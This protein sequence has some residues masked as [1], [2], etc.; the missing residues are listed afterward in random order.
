M[1]SNRAWLA[2]VACL[3][4]Q[5]AP[6][7]AAAKAVDVSIVTAAGNDDLARVR[8]LLP[9]HAA[10]VNQT[11]EDGATALAWAARNGNI[12]MARL[13]IKAG[14]DPNRLNG[15]GVGPLLLAAD[16]GN[17]ELV[18]L[19]LAAGA[20]PNAT[21]WNKETALM[22]AARAGSAASIQALV[23]AGADV[24]AREARGGQTALMWAAASGK[25]AAVRA[26]LGAKANA[27]LA[28]PVVEVGYPNARASDALE[29]QKKG[30]F[31]ALLFAA[32][33]FDKDT[34]KALLD[35]G[36]DPNRAAADGSTPLLIS[37]YHH[38]NP[39]PDFPSDTEVVADL[40]TADLLLSR[41][42]D[43]NKADANGLTPL[44]AAVFVAQ[45]HDLLGSLTDVPVIVKPHD[46]MGEQAVAL[47][48]ARGANPNIALRQYSVPS[49]AGQDPRSGGHYANVTPFLLAAA[50]NKPALL[51]LMAASGR[52][53]IRGAGP[54]GI[55]L[56][57]AAVRLN[58]PPAVDVLIGAGAD[59]YIADAQGN[60]PLHLAA[61][62]R[63]GSGAIAEALIRAGAKLDAKNAQGKTPADIAAAVPAAAGGR[64]GRGGGAAP[65]SGDPI[66]QGLGI[67][68]FAG[69]TAKDVIAIRMAGGVPTPAQVQISVAPTRELPPA[70]QVRSKPDQ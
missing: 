35:A 45:G 47:L 44:A 33:S 1:S 22:H 41:G 16:E 15:Y 40:D 14:G 52:L 18:S 13:L 63:P 2:G 26:L 24:N 56:L 31:T 64:G 29:K 49:P 17:A 55:A 58:S 36:Q 10:G 50:F 67:P 32:G 48:L 46:K 59:V 12:A 23:R 6:A 54:N 25:A 34:V 21:T 9:G 42:A 19:L 39:K 37:L 66:V 8:A 70:L 30:G 7:A 57:P 28:T 62:S 11:D 61:A 68:Q 27:A 4:L 38:V 53:D 3:L 51:K 5:A 60:T 43:P 65:N 20:R 69:A